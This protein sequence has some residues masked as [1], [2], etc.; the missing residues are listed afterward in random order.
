MALKKPLNARPDSA[1]VNFTLGAF[2]ISLNLLAAWIDKHSLR[3][4]SLFSLLLPHYFYFLFLVYPL[5]LFFS[6]LGSSLAVIDLA[7]AAAFH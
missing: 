3:R 5:S 1:P 7:L 6:I 2:C 4:F